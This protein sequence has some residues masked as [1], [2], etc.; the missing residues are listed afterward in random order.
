MLRYEHEGTSLRIHSVCGGIS[1]TQLLS[2]QATFSI[3][4]TPGSQGELFA[5]EAPEYRIAAVLTKDAV[6]LRRNGHV[7]TKAIGS[8]KESV[9]ILGAWNPRRMQVAVVLDAQDSES[10]DACASLDTEP[11]F[12]P[13]STL[14]WARRFSLTPRRSYGSVQDFVSVLSEAFRQ[15]ER[16]IRDSNSV[17]IYWE[18]SSDDNKRLVPRPEP[19][20]MTN[21]SALLDDHSLLAGYQLIRES[22]AGLG[23]LDLRAVAPLANGTTASICIEGKHAHADAIEHGITDQLPEYMRRTSAD[24]GIY[25]V[26][27]FKCHAYDQPATTSLDLSLT[28]HK[29]R[30]LKNM[31]VEVLN[32]GLP[33][34]PSDARFEFT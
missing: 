31:S 14:K 19:Q 26:L 1:P 5:L 34:A 24:F 23:R 6:Q 11:T 2:N 25:L 28:L 20:V 30:P 3:N 22:G 16:K 17:R 33:E 15:V 29:V 4:V 18:Q 32:L 10:N 13:I 12:V 9:L 27:W 21:I 7:V 8:A